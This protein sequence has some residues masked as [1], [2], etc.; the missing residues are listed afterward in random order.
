MTPILGSLCTGLGACAIAVS[1]VW[2]IVLSS[3]QNHP[4]YGFRSKVT[5]MQKC[6]NAQDNSTCTIE[7]QCVDNSCNIG[8]GNNP[9]S[10]RYRRSIIYENTIDRQTGQE[11]AS[12]A[13]PDCRPIAIC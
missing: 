12:D 2:M 9:V 8:T 5:V 6:T 1:I 7:D 11:F 13:P 4:L 10:S 3:C